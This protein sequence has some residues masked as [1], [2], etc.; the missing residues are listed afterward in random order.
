MQ[1]LPCRTLFQP[2]RLDILTNVSFVPLTRQARVC[3]RAPDL[4]LGSLPGESAS[5]KDQTFFSRSKTTTRTRAIPSPI[6]L[7]GLEFVSSKHN[8]NTTTLIFMGFPLVT[9]KGGVQ[10]PQRG[11][12]RLHRFLLHPRYWH[13]P[14]SLS[15]TWDSHPLSTSTMSI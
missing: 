12:A 11:E 8:S 3:V 15:E 9:I 2:L 5:Y 13:S 4:G 6:L 7:Q 10:G 1:F 14:L